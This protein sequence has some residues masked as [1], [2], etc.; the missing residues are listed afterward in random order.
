MQ[1]AEEYCDHITNIKAQVY[2][3]VRVQGGDSYN[4]AV[5][6]VLRWVDMTVAVENKKLD[7]ERNLWF[8]RDRLDKMERSHRRVLEL[9]YLEGY[10]IDKVAEI[11]NY[12]EQNIRKIKSKAIRE[13]AEIKE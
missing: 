7:A 9:Y 11:M 10:K 4:L 5:E 8:I 3:S 2:D 13:F 1:K 12:S 6:S